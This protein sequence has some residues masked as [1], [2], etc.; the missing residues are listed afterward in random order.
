MAASNGSLNR[1]Y[2]VVWNTARAVWQAVA[3][4]GKTRGKSLS[5]RVQRRQAGGGAVLLL[6][7]ANK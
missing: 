7:I 1:I 4:T 3:E 5:S 2:R 6:P